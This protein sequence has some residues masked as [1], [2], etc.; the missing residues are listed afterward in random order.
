[1][2]RWHNALA[3]AALKRHGSRGWEA[4]DNTRSSLTPPVRKRR[5]SWLAGREKFETYPWWP[6]SFASPG[7]LVLLAFPFISAT[8]TQQRRALVLLD[9]GDEDLLV[10]RVTTQQQAPEFDVVSD[11]WSGAGLAHGARGSEADLL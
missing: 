4:I 2:N 6:A 5:R 10:V 8:G 9:S 3:G 11:S 7:D 1:M